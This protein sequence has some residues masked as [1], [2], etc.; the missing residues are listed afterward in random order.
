MELIVMLSLLELFVIVQS[1]PSV[2]ELL[3][4]VITSTAFGTATLI[5]SAAPAVVALAHI[6][7]IRPNNIKPV[8]V[9]TTAERGSGCFP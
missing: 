6:N 3:A 9:N 1:P 2:T 5:E 4:F 7:N 8:N